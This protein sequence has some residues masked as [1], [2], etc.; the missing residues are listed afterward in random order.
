MFDDGIITG[1]MLLEHMQAQFNM[2]H[3]SFA[4]ID[5]RFDRLEK[6]VD[7]L[8]VEMKEGFRDATEHRKALQI[9]LDATIRMQFRHDKELAVLTGRSIPDED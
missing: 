6:K 7:R 4:A 5:K 9:D 2:V 3:Q 8:E 1:K